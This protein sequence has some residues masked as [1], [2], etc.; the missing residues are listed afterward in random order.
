[1]LSEID[2]FKF[3][4]TQKYAEFNGR[5]SRGEYCRYILIETLLLVLVIAI[6][7][8]ITYISKKPEYVFYGIV[9]FNVVFFLPTLAIST[10]R[11]HDLNNPGWTSIILFI[12][13]INVLY[14]LY[15]LL[16][17][18]DITP[19]R[20]GYPTSFEIVTPKLSAEKDI[21]LS[22]DSGS[23]TKFILTIII[24]IGIIVAA[25][26]S[27]D[28]NKFPSNTTKSKPSQTTTTVNTSKTVSQSGSSPQST[29]TPQ[30]AVQPENNYIE[31]ST[32]ALQ[33]YYDRLNQKNFN[34]AYVLLSEQ[35]QASVGYYNTWRNGYNT[36]LNVTLTSTRVLSANPNQV[37][38]EYQ[39]HAKDSINGRVKHQFFTGNVTME[40]VN[41]TWY[42]KNQDGRLVS[43]YFE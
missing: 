17:K 19:N 5:A 41:S 39:L 3:S 24:L 26:V 27:M 22:P 43:S 25:F 35:Q 28:S 10:R 16:K 38:Y 36:T 40:K 12:P 11:A 33:S 14:S 37:I 30:P 32:N 9:L 34:G 31:Q 29:S 13:Y 42:I 23:A 20:Y 8:L 2:N 6:G 21:Q 4:F 1:M 7:L 18:G 15:L